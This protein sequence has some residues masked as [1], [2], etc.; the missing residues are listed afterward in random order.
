VGWVLLKQGHYDAAMGKFIEAI[1]LD[2]ANTSFREH[3][4]NAL[5]QQKYTG[6]DFVALEAALKDKPTPE[7]Q[8]RV[9][10]LLDR[11]GK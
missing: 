11:I 9:R 7:N 5:A 2:G 8:A 6:R 1:R 10:E 3:L 4:A